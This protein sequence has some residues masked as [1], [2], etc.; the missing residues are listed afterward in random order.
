MPDMIINK[1]IIIHRQ[2]TMLIIRAGTKEH[3][4]SNCASPIYNLCWK[5]WSNLSC[6]LMLYSLENVLAPADPI[7]VSGQLGCSLISFEKYGSAKSNLSRDSSWKATSHE[8]QLDESRGE[9]FRILYGISKFPAS[10]LSSSVFPSTLW[11]EERHS[12]A[13]SYNK[14]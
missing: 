7:I 9:G 2:H 3:L 8:S 10:L 1:K 5:F 12:K 6:W 13:S 14:Y 4:C 11:E